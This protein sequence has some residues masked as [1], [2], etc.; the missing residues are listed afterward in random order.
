MS[1]QHK[2]S[3][4]NFIAGAAVTVGAAATAGLVG[5]GSSTSS[6]TTST[7]AADATATADTTALT[8][9]AIDSSFL[10][11]PAAIDDSKITSTIEADVVVVGCG[12]AGLTA[13]RMAAEQGATVAVIEK[14][15]SY[16][17]RSGQY[18]IY[19]STVQQEKGMNFDVRAAVNDLM[20][21]MGYRPDERV[22]DLYA[23]YSGPAFD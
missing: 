1:E 11:A 18:G 4:R 10:N 3:R 9:T 23:D 16:V 6:E 14:S 12:V 13:A 8:G 7:T 19:N 2:I 5:C 20:K 22:W 15:T 17:Y 21:E